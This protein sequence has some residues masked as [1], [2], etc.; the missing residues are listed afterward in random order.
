M[1]FLPDGDAVA[2]ARARLVD[3][4]VPGEEGW[5]STVVAAPA[6][7]WVVRT[8][9]HTPPHEP[10]PLGKPDY[11]HSVEPV[12]PGAREFRVEQVHPAR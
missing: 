12:S 4:G 9:T 11:V 10:R 2:A 6:S 3:D 1:D 7:G 8:W 5:R